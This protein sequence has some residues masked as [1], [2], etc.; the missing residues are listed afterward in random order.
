MSAPV[1]HHTNIE[2]HPDIQ[3]MRAKH[4]RAAS[5]PT[6]GIFEGLAFLAGLFIAIS[7]WIVGFY[8]SSTVLTVSSL[9]IGLAI[10]ALTLTLGSNY[11]RTHHIGWALPL[12]G[13][14]V[15]ISQ[16]VMKGA[17]DNT[18]IIVTNVIGG[19]VAAFCGLAMMTFAMRKG[20][21]TAR[22]GGGDTEMDSG[23]ARRGMRHGRRAAKMTR[24]QERDERDR[25]GGM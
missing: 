13:A 22:A 12:M 6:G 1:S 4:D 24:A 17:P 14:W 9:V 21:K 15:L 10:S 19:G 5:G 18:H 8:T 7:P 3:A 16:W 23:D 20:K 2:D 25:P 11:G